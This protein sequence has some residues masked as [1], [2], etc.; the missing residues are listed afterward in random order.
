MFVYL[1]RCANVGV[2]SSGVSAAYEGLIRN[3]PHVTCQ[4]ILFV[5]NYKNESVI[6]NIKFNCISY[7][8]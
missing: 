8:T 1:A 3:A 2:C 5:I 4:A 6:L 7:L